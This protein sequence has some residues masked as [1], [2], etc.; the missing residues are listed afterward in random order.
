MDRLHTVNL[1]DCYK[2]PIFDYQVATR[3]EMIEAMKAQGLTTVTRKESQGGQTFSGMIRGVSFDFSLANERGGTR[4]GY[5]HVCASF[6]CDDYEIVTFDKVAFSAI[7]DL[8]RVAD[9]VLGLSTELQKFPTVA[10][11]ERNLP[12]VDSRMMW[13]VSRN[14][15]ISSSAKLAI[16]WSV[17]ICSVGDGFKSLDY[18]YLK[19][20]AKKPEAVIQRFDVWGMESKG[21]EILKRN[22]MWATLE[23]RKENNKEAFRLV[24]NHPKVSKVEAGEHGAVVTLQTIP[25]DR[26]PE[27][28]EFLDSLK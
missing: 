3:D 6:K 9:Q 25:V 5:S 16:G 19:S 28:L 23:K 27:L 12:G 15:D 1:R 18:Q 10:A 26:I 2:A 24:N 4:V 11:I 21:K 14:I 7:P 17:T 20:T 22:Q 8:H 13:K